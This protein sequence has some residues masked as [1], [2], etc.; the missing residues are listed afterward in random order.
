[1][2]SSA[3]SYML[4][5]KTP[6]WEEGIR[7]LAKQQQTIR[8]LLFL[9]III[10]EDSQAACVGGI[11]GEGEG[12]TRESDRKKRR[13][14]PSLFLSLFLAPPPPLRLHLLCR[15]VFKLHLVFYPCYLYLQSD[16]FKELLIIIIIYYYHGFQGSTIDNIS[17][18]I[19]H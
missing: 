4:V 7:E 3:Y 12:G 9:S 19:F 6:V 8:K 17:L 15:V 13:P 1:M 10:W 18:Q 11:I 5:S 16:T 14:N 2:H